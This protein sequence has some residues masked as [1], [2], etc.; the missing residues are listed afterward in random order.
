MKRRDGGTFYGEL[1]ESLLQKDGRIFGTIG[2]IR[3]VTDRRQTEMALRS[4]LHEKE[5]L[6][7]EIHHRVKNNMQVISSLLNLQSAQVEDPV[8]KAMFRDSQFRIRS[9]AL[10]HE[11]LYRSASL[12]QIDFS[13]YIRK[14]FSHLSQ[15]LGVSETRIAA[16]FDFEEIFLDINTAIPLGLIVSELVTNAMKHAF[17]WGRPGEIRLEL[18][19]AETGEGWVLI[20]ADDGVGFPRSLDFQTMDSLGLQIVRLLVDQ[21]D[22]EIELMKEPGTCFRLTFREVKYPK[23]I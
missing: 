13:E 10:V 18:H 3:D 16:R 6:L 11:S 20:V 23:R 17:P 5:V 12:S 2:L 19:R 1:N 4:A 9:M 21:L 7:R 22:A 14:L 8:I 15:A